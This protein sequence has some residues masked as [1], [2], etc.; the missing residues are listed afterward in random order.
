MQAQNNVIVRLQAEQDRSFG[1]KGKYSSSQSR[2]HFNSDNSNSRNGSGAASKNASG[3][4]SKIPSGGYV[5]RE[6]GVSSGN[7]GKKLIGEINPGTQGHQNSNL[8]S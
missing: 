5:S 2:K 1:S 8:N 7:R 6:S 4:A 3:V